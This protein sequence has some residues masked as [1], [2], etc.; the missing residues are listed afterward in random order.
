VR[1]VVG[2]SLDS[3]YA[4]IFVVQYAGLAFADGIDV[5]D[6]VRSGETL[7]FAGTFGCTGETNEVRLSV[8]RLSNTARDYRPEL[9]TTPG[10]YGPNGSSPD[11]SVARIDPYGWLASQSS[12]NV[13]PGGHRWYM[14]PIAGMGPGGSTRMGGGA[15]SIALWISEQ[16]P[17]R[18]CDR[19]QAEWTISGGGRS[20]N[21][22]ADCGR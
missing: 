14:T 11:N 1:H 17:P 5:G 7:G 13:D 4:E 15:L 16:A 9:D 3:H 22:F 6:A 8:L 12:A 20:A 21:P 2:D 19:N 18:P 10:V